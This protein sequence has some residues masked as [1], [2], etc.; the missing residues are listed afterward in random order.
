MA[1]CRGLTDPRSCPSRVNRRQLAI[2]LTAPSRGIAS[3]TLLLWFSFAI[4]LMANYFL[5][6][7][8]PVLFEAK[9]VDSETAAVVTSAYHLGA[10]LG[11]LAM[12]FLLD[13]WGF[14]AVTGMLILAGPALLLI[15][16]PDLPAI[17]LALLAAFAGFCVLGAQFGNNAAAGIIYPTAYRSKGVGLAFAAGRVGSIAGPIIGAV[18]LGMR[19]PLHL[20]LL[21]MAL[22]LLLGA[23]ATYMLARIGRRRFG[24]WSLDEAS[25]EEEG[26]LPA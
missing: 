13:R 14:L 2:R 1:E 9:G 8:M 5:N 18:M 22:P 7:W 24:S 10:A 26:E 12:S 3:I 15:G 17:G 20:L 11:G 19:L 23:L 4:T 21:A 6:S 25:A 16:L